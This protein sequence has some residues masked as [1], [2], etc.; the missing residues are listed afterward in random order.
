V[1]KVKCNEY[2]EKIDFLQTV[3]TPAL[4]QVKK[5]CQNIEKALPKVAHHFLKTAYFYLKSVHMTIKKTMIYSNYLGSIKWKS[6]ERTYMQNTVQNP[7]QCTLFLGKLVHTLMILLFSCSYL[8]CGMSFSVFREFMISIEDKLRDLCRNPHH[9]QWKMLLK[10]QNERV[11][12]AHATGWPFQNQVVVSY[13][14]LIFY[15][16]CTRKLY[17]QIQEIHFYAIAISEDEIKNNTFA[18]LHRATYD[19]LPEVSQQHFI[20]L[21]NVIFLLQSMIALIMHCYNLDY[22]TATRHYINK[23]LPQ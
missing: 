2:K 9:V 20:P 13:F 10:S 11:V 4:N 21:P 17:A 22:N 14:G 12:R 7:N 23:T 1:D 16:Y 18:A 15:N 5:S 3:M 6:I 19:L 8:P